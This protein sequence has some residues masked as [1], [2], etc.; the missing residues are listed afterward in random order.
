M[1]QCLLDTD[2][3][4]EIIK[5]KNANVAARAS[6]YLS[7]YRQLTTSAISVAE[8]IYGL[9]RVGRE[10]RILQFELAVD[11]AQALPFD[12]GAARLAG[13]INGELVRQG[14]II[15]MPDV[16]I[17]A[18]ALRAGIAVV[19]GNRSHFEQVSAVGYQLTVLNW[20]DA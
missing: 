4:S 7:A 3:L 6:A 14:R 16:M 11:L 15:G 10:D 18:I 5:G 17:A 8:V 9:R 20:R 12:D 2:I 1:T 19:T 13:R